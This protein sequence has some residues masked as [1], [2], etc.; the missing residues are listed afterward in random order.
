MISI[1]MNQKFRTA[2]SAIGSSTRTLVV[3][4]RCV[5]LSAPLSE[6][7]KGKQG[8]SKARDGEFESL[9]FS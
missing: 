2:I 6:D 8:T 9:P 1:A 7:G 3:V 4:I 5:E